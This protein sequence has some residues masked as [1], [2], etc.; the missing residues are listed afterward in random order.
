MSTHRNKRSLTLD[1]TT[2]EGQGILHRL[3]ASAGIFINNLPEYN[4][5][6]K[7]GLDPD[8]CLARNPRLIH[9]CITSAATP[10]RARASRATPSSR[11]G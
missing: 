10:G 4:S 11:R 1:V 2:A 7:L 3:V 8:V 6:Q 5:L 9:V